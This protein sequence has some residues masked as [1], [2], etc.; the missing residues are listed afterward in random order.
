MFQ[1]KGVPV[2]G[3]LS[4]GPIHFLRRAEGTKDQ[5]STLSPGE[6]LLRFEAARERT[7]TELKRLQARIAAHLGDNEAAIFLFQSVMLEDSD[8]LDA[9]R[10]YINNSATAEYAV[11]QA[12][13]TIIDFFASLSSSYLRS[14]STDARDMSRRLRRNLSRPA[15][16]ASRHRHPAILAADELTPSET[17][18]LDAGMLLGMVSRTGTADNHT[19][20]LAQ[21]IGIPALIGVEVDPLWEGRL[22]ILDGDNGTLTIDPEPEV[23]EKAKP[24]L[25]PDYTPPAVPFQLSG[26]LSVRLSA[27]IS[28]AWEAVDAYALGADGIA[29]Y[30]T[31][32]LFGGR[33]T[34]PSEEEQLIEYRQTLEAMHGRPVVFQSFDV[35]GIGMDGL[36]SMLGRPDRYNVLKSQLRAILRASAEGP[37]SIALSGVRS[38]SEIRYVRQLIRTCQAELDTEKQPYQEIQV[39]VEIA[40][41][42]SV[43]S[44]EAFAEASDFLLLDGESLMQSTVPPSDTIALPSYH[45]LGWMLRRV[46]LAAGRCGC[47]VIFFGDLEHF[48]QAVSPLLKLG[49]DEFSVQ[50]SSVLP[51]FYL[52]SDAG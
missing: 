9:V 37:A 14:R 19:S 21:A 40:Q 50:P 32:L 47:R 31:D 13:K 25:A 46:T 28:S 45:A 49:I 33:E 35:G 18:L 5:L 36:M 26:R 8:Y 16:H 7:F 52:L 38:K 23:L 24:H 22:A 10:S 1:I 6:E 42:V 29:A 3:G 51:L 27:S 44:A 41:P 15:D 4:I 39:G 12:E 17:V 34:P 11:E 43:L 20:I 48:P 2:Q 30:R